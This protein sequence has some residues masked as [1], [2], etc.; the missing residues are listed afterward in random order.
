MLPY[1]A[2]H[3]MCLLL[4][5]LRF[6]CCT[7]IC[8]RGYFRQSPPYFHGRSDF[9]RLPGHPWVRCSLPESVQVFVLH[10]TYGVRTDQLGISYLFLLSLCYP[11]NG[12]VLRA[13][14]CAD[15]NYTISHVFCLHNHSVLFL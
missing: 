1:A 7:A 8:D 4:R 9:L 11:I 5:A 13:G 12:V 6:A 3:I 2:Q 10:P 14:V 15:L